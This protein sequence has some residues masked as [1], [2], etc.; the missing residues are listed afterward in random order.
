MRTT[1][2]LIVI[3]QGGMCVLDI[4]ECDTGKIGSR[5]S[6]L[7]CLIE[8]FILSFKLS[9]VPVPPRAMVSISRMVLYGQRKEIGIRRKIPSNNDLR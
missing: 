5:A 8:S 6:T 3:T 9:P 1:D 4:L 2:V 7:I